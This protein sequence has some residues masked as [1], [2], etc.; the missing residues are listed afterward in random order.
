MIDEA[1]AFQQADEALDLI[2]RDGVADADV[3]AAAFFERAAAIDADELAGGIEHRSAGVAGIDGGIGLQAV[4][5]FEQRA[6]GKLVAMDAGEDAVGYGG[7]EIVGEQKRIA[8]DVD[9]LADAAGVAVAELGG[10]KIAFA[11][12]LDKSDVAARIEPDEHG[13]DEAAIGEAALHGGAA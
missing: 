8:D 6:G 4:G 1:T 2:D 5:V 7:F 12:Q 9:P 3:D 11:E 10:R 13:V